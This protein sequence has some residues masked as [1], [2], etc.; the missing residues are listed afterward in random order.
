M[1][2]PYQL[3]LT[4][5]EKCQKETVFSIYY[6]QS[7]SINNFPLDLAHFHLFFIDSFEK[8]LESFSSRKIVNKLAL[9]H[10]TNKITQVII[11]K[12]SF[13]QPEMSSSLSNLFH[14]IMEIH[15][16]FYDPIEIQLEKAFQ[17][18]V[19]VNKLLTIKIHSAFIFSFCSLI[20][21][22]FLLIFDIYI[23]AG[24]KRLIWLHSKYEYN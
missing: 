10:N 1:F 24:I 7:N 22:S 2:I 12:R 14:S 15:P 4:S 23:Y 11:A 21:F 9:K 19:M 8:H 3:L 17:E 16:N 5:Q 6:Q 18:K 20:I 13:L